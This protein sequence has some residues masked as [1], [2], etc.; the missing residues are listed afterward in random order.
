MGS[1]GP[2]GL[3]SAWLE[4]GRTN[5]LKRLKQYCSTEFSNVFSS[6]RLRFDTLSPRLSVAHSGARTGHISRCTLR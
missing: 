4:V 3:M 2:C 5:K 1:P 6:A